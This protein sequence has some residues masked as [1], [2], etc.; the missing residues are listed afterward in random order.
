MNTYSTRYSRLSDAEVNELYR[1]DTWT[2]LNGKERLE[3]LQELENRS[4]KICGNQPYKVQLEKMNGATY[5]GYHNGKIYINKDLVENG[6]FVVQY[7]DGSTQSFALLDANAQLMDTIHH[8][9]YHAY[10][11]DAIHGRVKH[12]NPAEVEQ[13][14]A[15]FT[16]GNYIRS[17]E[18]HN[19]YRIQSLEKPAFERGESQTRAAFERIEAKHGKDPGYQEYLKSTEKNSYEK[20]LASAKHQYGDE[21]IENTIND[22]MR[23]N[24][25]ASRH[26]YAKEAGAHRQQTTHTKEEMQ[27]SQNQQEQEKRPQQEDDHKNEHKRVRQEKI[28]RMKEQMKTR[29]KQQSH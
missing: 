6:N 15:N 12:S 19:L 28:E 10:Q 14:R 13:W 26:H 3:A 8:E 11:D 27:N 1:S 20:A 2:R 24:Y 17:E 5:G 29:D 22:R 7:R 4:A 23:Q 9:N 25:Q 16:Q 21:N 18:D